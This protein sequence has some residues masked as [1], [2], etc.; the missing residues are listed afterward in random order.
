MKLQ[1][2]LTQTQQSPPCFWPHT[3]G[4]RDTL[5]PSQL[6]NRCSLARFIQYY[7]GMTE[8]TVVKLYKLTPSITVKADFVWSHDWDILA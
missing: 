1:T 2:H 7:P 6:D 8:A 5:K 3:S 4:R